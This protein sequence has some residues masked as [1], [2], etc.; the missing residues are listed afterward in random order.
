MKLVLAIVF[1]L[2]CLAELAPANPAMAG[3]P[4]PTPHATSSAGDVWGGGRREEDSSKTNT[5]ELGTDPADNGTQAAAQPTIDLDEQVRT[6]QMFNGVG[7]TE[8][9]DCEPVNTTN[10]L[11]HDVPAASQLREVAAH[12]KPP[13]ATPLN[14]PGMS[15]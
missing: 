10:P 1:S 3:K 12:L 13:D 5:K 11:K 2:V 15:G 6:C 4:A 9:D 14:R 7:S 8:P